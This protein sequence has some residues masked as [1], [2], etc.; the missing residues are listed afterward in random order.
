MLGFQRKRLTGKEVWFLHCIPGH[1]REVCWDGSARPWA[2]SSSASSIFTAGCTVHAL[3]RCA[4]A[5]LS[6]CQRLAAVS[7]WMFRP[8]FSRY[9][10]NAAGHS[11]SPRRQCSPVLLHFPWTLMCNNTSSLDGANQLMISWAVALS[12]SI[13]NYVAF[14]RK[15]SRLH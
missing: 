5:F 2:N 1:S 10:F 11:E 6:L 13:W 4:A 12:M 3:W 14:F 9:L 15:K 7:S 8:P